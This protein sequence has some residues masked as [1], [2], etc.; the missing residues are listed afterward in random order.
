VA[1]GGVPDKGDCRR[2]PLGREPDIMKPLSKTIII[3]LGIGIALVVS[4]II[5]PYFSGTASRNG[6]HGENSQVSVF[7]NDMN[8]S[9]SVHISLYNSSLNV[10]AEGSYEMAS[11]NHTVLTVHPLPYGDMNYSATFIVDGNI[12]THYEQLAISSE[13]SE[14]FSVDPNGGVMRPYEMWC[15]NRA[16]KTQ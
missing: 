10:Q 11:G 1:V 12:S 6:S 16:C 7:N 4:L 2:I 8:R 13:C 5:F 15:A 3:G 9:H 14:T